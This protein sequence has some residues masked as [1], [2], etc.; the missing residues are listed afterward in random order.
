MMYQPSAKQILLAAI[1][2]ISLSFASSEAFGQIRVADYNMHGYIGNDFHHN[3]PTEANWV[4]SQASPGVLRLLGSETMNGISV[5]PSILTLEEVFHGSSDGAQVATWLNQVYSTAGSNYSSSQHVAG[6]S[7]DY[8]FVYDTSKVTLVDVTPVGTPTRTS[9]RAHF[10]ING[11]TG[12]GSDLYVYAVHTKAYEGYENTRAQ[13]ALA[14][15]S[16]ASTLP[17]GSNIIYSGDWN[18]TTLQYTKNANNVPTGAADTSGEPGY[19]YMTSVGSNYAFDPA[20]GTG[21]AGETSL[22]TGFALSNMTYSPTSFSSRIDYSFASVALGDGGGMDVI[23]VNTATPSYETVGNVGIVYSPYPSVRSASDHAPVLLDLQVP[24]KMSVTVN[25]MASRV[26]VGASVNAGI[27]V[28]NSANV[29]A[30][31]GADELVYSVTGSGALSGSANGVAY[32]LNAG[33]NHSLALNTTTTG[34]KSGSISVIST[35]PGVANGTFSQNVSV[36]VV[37]HAHA[38]FS[39]S[40]VANHLTMDFGTLSPTGSAVSGQFE[41]VNLVSVV[42]YTA[43]LDLDN[44][45]MT[46]SG[47]FSTDLQTFKN[48][49]AGNAALFSAFLDATQLGVF[50]KII[51]LSVSDEDLPGEATSQIVL[52]LKG[53]V[54]GRATGDF[55]DDGVINADDYTVWATNYASATQDDFADGNNDGFINADDYTIW[56]TFY[57]QSLG[58]TL[59]SVQSQYSAIPEPTSLGLLGLAAAGLL[60]RRRRIA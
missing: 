4:G 15:L 34:N 18:F 55:N 17:T 30:S 53:H 22:S 10:Q 40:Q 19:A 51:T 49:A 7:E 44:I 43:A 37:D 31:N 59:A 11:Y 20:V 48:L 1:A 6:G 5:A 60:S 57:A 54:S 9:Y 29:V 46:G 42:G 52:T 21:H 25:P 56:A 39:D 47:A 41:I 8:A 16:N 35:S 27:N 38:S 24:A 58:Q 28:S 3:V 50:E 45:S 14:L 33:N 12:T 36:D 32:A 13:T 23:G 26:I 2:G